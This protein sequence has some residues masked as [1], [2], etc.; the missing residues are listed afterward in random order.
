MDDHHPGGFKYPGKPTIFHPAPAPYG[1]PYRSLYSRN[2]SNLFVAGRNISATHAALSSTRVMATC[3]MMGQAVGAAASIGVK[4]GLEPRGVYEKKINELKQTLMED[5][6]YLPWNVRKVSDKTKNAAIWASSGDASKLVNGID[7][8][9]G[10]EYNGWIA[11]MGSTVEFD[12]GHE[13]EIEG[14]TLTFDSDLNRETY[15]GFNRNIKLFP[16]RCNVSLGE[17][18]VYVPKTLIKAFRIEAADSKGNWN[19]IYREA[20]NYQRFVKINLETSAAKI[21][22]VPEETWGCDEVRLFAVDIK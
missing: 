1:I 17:K 8:P 16:M 3:A 22:I 13:T 21:R 15:E 18:A 6:C 12:F 10:S 11:P 19:A 7:R 9:I 14:I 2:I 4:Y 5:D 20:N